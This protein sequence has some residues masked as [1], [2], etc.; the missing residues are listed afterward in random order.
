[1]SKGF[2]DRELAAERSLAQTT[3]ELKQIRK[4]MEK[5]PNDPKGRAK[6]LKKLKKY[7]RSPLGELQRI[8]YE[9]GK[10]E[11]IPVVEPNPAP[12]VEEVEETVTLT[13]EDKEILLDSLRK[14]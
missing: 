10:T 3:R 1:M 2:G 6:M 9:P 5:Y 4:V 11:F 12:D 7:W 14:T 13:E 8:A